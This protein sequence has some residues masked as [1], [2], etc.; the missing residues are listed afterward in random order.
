MTTRTV[1]RTG[2]PIEATG[3]R[4]EYFDRNRG[5]RLVA[6]EDFELSVRP[7]EFMCLVGPS[8]CGKS[9]FLKAVG[10]LVPITAGRIGVGDRAISGPGRDRAVVFQSPSLLPWRTVLGNVRFGMQCHG[11]APKDIDERARHYAE[12]VGLAGFEDDY[13]YQLS[14]GMQQRVNLARA[15]SVDPEI[16]LMDE[17]FA[18]LD[19]QTREL[20]QAE[21]LDIWQAD[22]KTV[23]FVTHQVSEAVLLGDRVA[24][25]S[26]RPGRVLKVIDIALPRP[27]S[28]E[29]QRDP[30]MLAYEDEVRGL[31]RPEAVRAMREENEKAKGADVPG[32]MDIAP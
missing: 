11:I 23:I 13:P 4:I 18:A 30:K 17:P 27:R 7:G 28:T 22:K 15:L 8:G 3:V 12:R 9:T 24:I 1:Q 21:L 25:M 14:G 5:R 20:M 2:R 31:L 10:G 32:T 16:L 26:A 6:L 29:T 19:A